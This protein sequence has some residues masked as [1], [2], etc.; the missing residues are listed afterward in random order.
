LNARDR[1]FKRDDALLDCH[2]PLTYETPTQSAAENER[3]LHFF[4]NPPE[5]ADPVDPKITAVTI[6]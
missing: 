5:I 2:R 6:V 1:P 3:Q 4:P